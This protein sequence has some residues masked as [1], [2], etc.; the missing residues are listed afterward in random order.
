[1]LLAGQVPP[2]EFTRAELAQVLIG[3]MRDGAAPA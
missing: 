2:P 3:G 1:M